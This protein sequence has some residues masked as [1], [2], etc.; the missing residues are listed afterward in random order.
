[1][2]VRMN[3]LTNVLFPDTPDVIIEDVTIEGNVLVFSL[4]S[5]RVCAA[6]PVCV[7]S[8]T[9]VHGSYVRKPA[10]VP[11]LTY[12]VC[13]HLHVRRF[14]CQNIQCERKT[15]AEPFAGLVVAYA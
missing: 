10:D 9:K 13:L 4:R 2:K 6:C 5:T 11:C 3:L 1:M 12:A 14:L 15:F 8:S 7:C